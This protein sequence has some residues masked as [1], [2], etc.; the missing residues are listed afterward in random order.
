MLNEIFFHVQIDA[1]NDTLIPRK[2]W[3]KISKPKF[4]KKQSP[5]EA[6]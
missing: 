3:E 4:R 6:I 5:V 1:G 2:F